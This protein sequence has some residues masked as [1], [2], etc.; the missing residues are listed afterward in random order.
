MRGIPNFKRKILTAALV[1]FG[2]TIVRLREQRR[3]F[4]LEIYILKGNKTALQETESA[5]L[6][7]AKLMNP[8]ESLS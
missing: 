1:D 7:S 8:A 3:I 6:E 4:P 5:R 2:E